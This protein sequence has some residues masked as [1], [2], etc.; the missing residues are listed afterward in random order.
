MLYSFAI[1]THCILDNYECLETNV[2]ENKHNFIE[3]YVNFI[4]KRNFSFW[5]QEEAIGVYVSIS[6]NY[7]PRI[8]AEYK[9]PRIAESEKKRIMKKNGAYGV[10]S[11][12]FWKLYVYT[13]G[14][15][16][17]IMT[18][19]PLGKPRRQNQI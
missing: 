5:V 3:H 8:F 4:G 18:L 19:E 7:I 10:K 12:D 6:C 1:D 16:T 13:N 11:S 17:D 9:R 14:R 15:L 2:R